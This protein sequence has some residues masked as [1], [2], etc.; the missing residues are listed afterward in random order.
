MIRSRFHQQNDFPPANAL[1]TSKPTSHQQTR[2]PNAPSHS[3]RIPTGEQ[4]GPGGRGTPPK[5]LY[6][7]HIRSW[8]RCASDGAVLAGRWSVRTVASSHAAANGHHAPLMAM[9]IYALCRGPY[10]YNYVCVHMC[11]RFRDI[12]VRIPAKRLGHSSCL[13]LALG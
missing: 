7:I 4:A 3:G 10:A 12:D 9:G 6:I 5:A 2:S 11:V 13:W 8:A 1:I